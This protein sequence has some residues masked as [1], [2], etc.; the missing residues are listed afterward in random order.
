[1]GDGPLELAELPS[2]SLE[3]SHQLEASG[4][5]ETAGALVERRHRDPMA[6]VAEPLRGELEDRSDQLPADALTDEVRSQSEPH[7]EGPLDGH[8]A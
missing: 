5:A 4:L 8:L 3:P 6:V 7:V 2:R 1:M